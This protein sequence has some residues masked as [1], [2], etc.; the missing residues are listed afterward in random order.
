MLNK[1]RNITNRV[2]RSPTVAF[3]NGRMVCHFTFCG[4]KELDAA[5]Y[6]KV[7]KKESI[8]APFLSSIEFKQFLSWLALTKYFQVISLA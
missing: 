6:P 2:C 8:E 3:V 1:Q 4:S 7:Q 5:V